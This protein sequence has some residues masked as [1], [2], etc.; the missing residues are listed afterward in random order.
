MDTTQNAP[1]ILSTCTG[2][3]GLERGIEHATGSQLNVATYVEI[4]AFVNYNLVAAMEQGL[5]APAPIYTNLKT[6][7]A[8]PFRNRIH[9]L[10]GGYPCQPFSN[11]GLR[12]GIE[13]PRH[14]Y[15][16]IER[17]IQ[18][19]N[20][21]WCYF[22]NVEGH[23]NLGFSEVQ[24]S[25]HRLGYA[26]EADL[27][28]A[29]EVGATHRRTRLFILAIRKDVLEYAHH[30]RNSTP[31]G[32]TNPNGAKVEQRRQLLTF[33]GFGRSFEKLEYPTCRRSGGL[34]NTP[35]PWQRYG[36]AGRGGVSTEKT[37]LAKPHSFRHIYEQPYQYTTK[38]GQYA[39]CNTTTGS[40]EKLAHAPCHGFGKNSIE[41]QPKQFSKNETQWPAR[42]GQPQREWE[43][44][45]TIGN[46]YRLPN[47]LRTMWSSSRK[48][49][50]KIVGEKIWKETDFRI[51]AHL[52]SGM[53]CTVNGYNFTTDLLRLYGNGVVYQQAAHAFNSLIDKHLNS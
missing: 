14:L 9:G 41:H 35:S 22:E 6:F 18:A 5:L 53:G 30:T 7:D 50:E 43:E 29:S 13:D 11:A 3:R 2:S 23:L 47:T 8:S 20:P 31:R 15:P 33:L 26:V 27:Y 45:R 19:A 10:I 42:P 17:T 44:P 16:Y 12:K 37:E 40:S 1:V 52:E 24:A 4:E 36:L 25:L 38:G 48:S 46:N 39:L 34:P 51:K 49:F 21:I 32:N 28:T